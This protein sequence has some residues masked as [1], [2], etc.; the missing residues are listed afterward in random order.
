[1][2]DP[3]N[4]FA[5]LKNRLTTW[6]RIL[7]TTHPKILTE[8]EQRDLIDLLNEAIYNINAGELLNSSAEELHKQA[9]LEQQHRSVT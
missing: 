2:T 7:Q 8:D 6:A 5:N 9:L 3:N 1:M 4:T